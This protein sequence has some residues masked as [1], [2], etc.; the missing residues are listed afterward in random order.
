MREDQKSKAKLTTRSCVVKKHFWDFEGEIARV[1]EFHRQSHSGL[2]FVVHDHI[3]FTSTDS[4]CV[5]ISCEVEYI[6]TDL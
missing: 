1:T 2:R 3:V 5:R 6:L 4:I